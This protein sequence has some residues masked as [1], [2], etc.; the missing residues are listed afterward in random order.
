MTDRKLAEFKQILQTKRAGLERGTLSREGI[1]VERTADANDEAQSAQDR[2]LTI[3]AIDHQSQLL[4]A[5][6]FALR[7]IEEGEYGICQHCEDPISIKRLE[8]VPW[9][10][11]CIQ[12][13][14]T[15]DRAGTRLGEG[16]FASAAAF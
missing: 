10:L 6:K 7:R 12:C 16:H 14:E 8:A 11:Y 13:Q 15:A 1:A 5:V 3:R 9:T 2:E 4:S